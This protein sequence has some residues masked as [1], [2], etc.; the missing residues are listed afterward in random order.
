MLHAFFVLL[1]A[2]SF[3]LVL[4]PR[5]FCVFFLVPFLPKVGV[6]RLCDVCASLVRHGGGRGMVINNDRTATTGVDQ[7]VLRIAVLHSPCF[8][9]SQN[10][11]VYRQ[12][13][14]SRSHFPSSFPRLVPRRVRST[15]M[16]DESPRTA[17][18]RHRWPRRFRTPVTQQRPSSQV[19]FAQW[20]RSR[21]FLLPASL[22]H[23][24]RIRWL[25]SRRLAC[26][27]GNDAV[28]Y[29]SRGFIQ[30]CA[31]RVHSLRIDNARVSV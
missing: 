5:L 9:S 31:R 25:V 29:R 26:V 10:C 27:S 8:N 12:P 17:A 28:G 7:N 3:L 16:G 1:H 23:I 20:A 2:L 19:A 21:P 6:A 24:R 14:T 22:P 15:R 18:A 11:D 13:S 4:L 30:I